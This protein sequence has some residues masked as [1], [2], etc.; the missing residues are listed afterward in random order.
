VP[1]SQAVNVGS[2]RT[3]WI[4]S[5]SFYYGSTSWGGC[6]D[7]REASSRDVTDDPPSVARFPAYY[8][9]D[10]SRNDWRTS[11][12]SVRS[13]IGPT[14]GPNKSCPQAVTPMTG[15]K[16]T[17]LSGINAMTAVGNTHINLGAAWGWR[18]L[19][20]RWRG[21]WGGTMDAASLPLNYNTTLM[22]KAAIIMTDG[23]N[24]MDN[25]NRTAYWYLSD[26]KL[27]TT[28]QSTAESRLDSR[29]SQICTSM[30]NNNIIVYTIS[31]GT[32]SSSSAT[33]M[34]NCAT[35]ADFYFASPSSAD[36][37]N[38]FRQIGDS[39]A[40]LRVSR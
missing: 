8:W 18:M 35:Q 6:V 33:M 28:N 27:G 15:N 37:Q 39:L 5:N 31:F 3:S 16:S 7:A 9:P 23:D 21:L 1:F 10:D 14:L 24:T 29:L 40:N 22:N 4:A 38:A 30:K 32:I 26:N 17:I 12:G 13:G 19:S 20:P 34:R 36:L 11:G 25:S 2:S